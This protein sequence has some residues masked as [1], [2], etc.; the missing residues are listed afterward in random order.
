[1][2]MKSTRIRAASIAMLTAAAVFVL[3][4]VLAMRAYPGGTDWA[5]AAPG[6]DFWLN[7]LCDLTRGVAL[8]GAANPLGSKLAQ[9]GIV[10]LALGLLPLWWLLPHLF[11]SHAR[12]GSAVRVLGS[13]AAAGTIAVVLMPSDQFGRLHAFAIVLACPPGLAAA[14]L[15][16][17]GLAREERRPRVAAGI[18]AT[19]LLTAAIDFV[20]YLGYLGTTGPMAVAVLERV[21]LLLLL[22][23]MAC[24]SIRARLN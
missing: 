7:Y 18:G 11:P 20:L 6:H 15:A 5:A 14:L 8:N 13:T 24:V 10:A 1:M 12:L 4:I 23:W 9:A 19:M 2:S 17:V 21:A 22:A 3:L 16:V